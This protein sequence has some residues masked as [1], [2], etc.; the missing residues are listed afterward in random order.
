MNKKII[1]I[2]VSMLL[3][4]TVVLPVISSESTCKIDIVKP[5]YLKIE[6]LNGE[7]EVKISIYGTLYMIKKPLG[8]TT[9]LYA[10]FENMEQN[11]IDSYFG[12][13]IKTISTSP[14]DFTFKTEESLILP[15]GSTAE[16]TTAF[17]LGIGIFKIT[18]FIEGTGENEGFYA[19]K[20]ANGICLG[21][22]AFVIISS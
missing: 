7:N 3:L 13:H 9:G 16:M 11:P 2:F 12:Y 17:P 19:E 15:S 21:I 10:T 4:L 14:I 1:G 22:Y 18:C 20:S 8:Q 5:E 6:Q